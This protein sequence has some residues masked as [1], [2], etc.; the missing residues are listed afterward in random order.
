M[1]E[2][3][4]KDGLKHY[5]D[6]LKTFVNK[7]VS[8]NKVAIGETA[9]KAYPGEKGKANADFISGI[10]A[11]NRPL[12]TP[13]LS[14]KWSIFNNAGTAVTSLDSTNLDVT[15]EDGFLAQWSGSFKWTRADGYK[16]PTVVSGNWNTVPASGVASNTYT[17]PNKAFSNASVSVTIGA[18]KTGLMVSGQD[19][20][21]A[22]G[23][24]TKSAW[25]NVY[26]KRRFYY[27]LSTNANVSADVI[28]ALTGTKLDTTKAQHLSGISANDSQ[29]YVI[30]YPKNMGE[31]AKIVQNG[32]TPLLNGGFVKS[33][34]KVTNAAGYAIDYYVYRTEKPG[35]LKDN[36]FLDIA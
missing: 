11:G 28:K 17:M 36:S 31:L 30:A 26:F 34:V 15:L 22:S 27:G 5:T 2:Y 3:L 21:P 29:Y 18:P 19:V 35:A 33:E 9:G 8:D 13:V 7:Q 24:D 1:A 10:K 23:N 25:A 6:V 16:D 4:D 12:P 14:G 20:K 32:A